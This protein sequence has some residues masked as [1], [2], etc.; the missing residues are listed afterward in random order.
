MNSALG[1]VPLPAK[2]D[3]EAETR[4]MLSPV[5]P[6]TT[7]TPFLPWSV[8]ECSIFKDITDRLCVLSAAKLLVDK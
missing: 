5:F 8:L 6:T 1:L 2:Y 7:V 4:Q 3:S